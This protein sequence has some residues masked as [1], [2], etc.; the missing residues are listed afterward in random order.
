MLGCSPPILEPFPGI[1]ARCNNGL[2]ADGCN[3]SAAC[4]DDLVCATLVDLP[5]IHEI[6]TC[7]LCVD[8]S[9][10]GTE[11]CSVMLELGVFGGIRDCVAS[12]S[13]ADGE[14]CD[15]AGSGEAACANRCAAA[16]LGG[17]VDVGVCSECS[18]D[19]HCDAGQTCAAPTITFDGAVTPGACV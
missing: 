2:H 12:G 11:L 9:D 4:T 7:S 14:T 10:C 19:E 13:L 3:T 15:L 1:P 17:L 6:R 8:D 16:D 18:L 5:G